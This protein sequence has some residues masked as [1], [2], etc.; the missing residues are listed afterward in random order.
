MNIKS[1][2]IQQLKNSHRYAFDSVLL[3]DHVFPKHN[4][5][6]LD[7]GCGCGVISMILAAKN[8]SITVTGVDIQESFSHLAQ[9]NVQQ[10]GLENQITIVCKDLRTIR[11]NTFE[12][13]HQVV[14][15]PP[16]RKKNAGRMN[17]SCE[18]AMAREEISCTIDDIMEASRK[19]LLYQGELCLIYPGERLADGLVK[20]RTYNIE[21]KDIIP[22]YSK[23]NQPAKWAIIKGRLDAKPGL[24]VHPPVFT[25]NL[26]QKDTSFDG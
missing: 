7:L 19:V 18:T 10:N 22:I 21:A 14:C 11:G 2:T 13:F 25:D 23:K 26:I 1:L 4:S 8:P 9:K 20:M 5:R 24:I 3:A 15:N 12:R 16:F 6:I 17:H